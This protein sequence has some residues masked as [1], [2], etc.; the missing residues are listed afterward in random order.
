MYLKTQYTQSILCLKNL[1]QVLGRPYF[2]QIIMP[3]LSSLRTQIDTLDREIL[4]LLGKRFEA[5]REVGSIKKKEGIAALQPSRWQEVLNNVVT[6][7]HENNIPE[8]YIREMYEL[9][10]KYSLEEEEDK[11]I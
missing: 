4:S 3:T 5:I 1:S 8:L 6:M 7:A 9:I 2:S 10:H 11:N